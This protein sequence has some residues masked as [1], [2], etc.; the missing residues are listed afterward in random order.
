[1]PTLYLMIKAIPEAVPLAP[2]AA[3]GS[4][5]GGGSRRGGGSRNAYRGRFGGGGAQRKLSSDPVFQGSYQD[6]EGNTFGGH[7]P[8]AVENF[9]SF[10][11]AFIKYVGSTY[12][13]GADLQHEMR[14]LKEFYLSALVPDTPKKYDE[15]GMV[16]TTRGEYNHIKEDVYTL[17]LRDRHNRRKTLYTNQKRVSRIWI[18]KSL[19]SSGRS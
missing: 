15:N 16:V 11:M 10:I 9:T 6:L 4:K 2:G 5:P 7:G 1:M 14:A 3:G 8:G 13:N 19:Q 12:T 18:C 17:E